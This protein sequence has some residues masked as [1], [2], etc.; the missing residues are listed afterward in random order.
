MKCLEVV[1][2]IIIFDGQILC[3]QRGQS[4]QNTFPTNLNSLAARSKPERP[5]LR[6]SCGN[7]GK[8]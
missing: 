6:R 5:K 3:M 2:A 4:V 8:K 1:A 7:S